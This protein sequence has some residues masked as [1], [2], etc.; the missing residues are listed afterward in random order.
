STCPSCRGSSPRASACATTRWSSRTALGSGGGLR[1]GEF[2]RLVRA[3]RANARELA[4]AA[5][6]AAARFRDVI[7]RLHAGDLRVRGGADGPTV[8]RFQLG[9]AHALV[10]A[11]LGLADLARLAV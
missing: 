4:L 9:L 5:F 3:R 11:R 8:A 7:A 1:R 10:G 2:P 6:R